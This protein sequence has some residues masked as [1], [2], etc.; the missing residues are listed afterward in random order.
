MWKR[1]IDDIISIVY[2]DEINE[3]LTHLNGINRHI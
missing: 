1:Y 2:K 3:L